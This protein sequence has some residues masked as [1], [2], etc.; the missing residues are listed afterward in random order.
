MSK[1]ISGWIRLLAVS[2]AIW[3]MNS[4][5]WAV[6]IE[7]IR[8]ENI[9][10]GEIDPASVTSYLMSK[11]GDDFDRG[12]VA[13]DVRTLQES[14]RF[15][16]VSVEVEQVG[17]G[18]DV[19]YSVERKLRL[20]TLKLE[21][22]EGISRSKARKVMA[23]REGDFLDEAALSVAA[24]RLEKEYEKRYYYNAKVTWKK[25]VDERNAAADIT[26]VVKEG[27]SV[28][29]K[30][31]EFDG[32]WAVEEK[33]LH[34]AMRQKTWSLLSLFNK[35]GRYK[36]GELEQD[37]ETIRNLYLNQGYLDVEVG[38][39]IVNVVD[40]ERVRITIPIDE[41]RIY[42]VREVVISGNEEYPEDIL[43]AQ[44]SIQPGTIA[45]T[46]EIE[47]SRVALQDYYGSRGYI[48]TRV[49]ADVQP[50]LDTGNVAVEFVVREGELASIRRI[51]IR[52]NDRTKDEVI[53]RELVVYPGEIYNEVKVKTSERRIQNLN[54]FQT[55]RSTPTATE[56]PGL[57]DMDLEVTEK[58]TGQFVVG[59]GFSS[60]DDL[61]GFME[62]SQ[63][64]FDLLGWPGFTGDGQKLRLR[65][66][67]GTQRQD[68]ELSFT[69]PWFLDRKLA[70]QTDF[71]RSDK[72]YLSSEYDQRN[73]GA[74]VGLAKALGRFFRLNVAYSL[75]EIVISDVAETASDII[76]EEEGARTKSALT[77]T[78][79][80]DSRDSFFVS[81]RGNRTS[82]TFEYAGGP[83]AGETDLYRLEAR[84]SH[85]VPLWLAHVLNLRGWA[86][87]V[88]PHGSSDRVPI[89]DRLFL[90]GARTLRGFEYRDVGP[91]DENGEPIGGSSGAF[92]SAE[93]TIPISKSFRVAAF[94]DIGMIWP[95]AYEFDTSTYN[96]DYGVGIR[97]DIPG[98]PLR[99]DYAW[100][101]EADEFNDR[102]SG[103]FNFM[104]GYVF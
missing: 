83:L 73:T 25:E 53:R 60:I 70:L 49:L 99:M 95:D 104:I 37:V 69:E 55:V 19:I 61:I 63:A 45:S 98:F 1:W 65:A 74:R 35:S 101:L 17:D 23:I 7:E 62:I 72:Q 89:F 13:R 90:G 8:I 30:E 58:R 42:L 38:E 14:G 41:G 31:I 92:A 21:G 24:R 57:Y 36:S 10:S 75:E 59:V 39:P 67:L 94:Y 32:N 22:L 18:V 6:R 9:G 56:D 76:K 84:T 33:V 4:S 77:T 85:Y 54:F 52:G 86:S 87:V 81:T 48:R 12:V 27:P 50:D 29:L 11:K 34:K 43:M 51:N 64:N 96:S 103:R 82:L 47:R 28:R 66:Q 79:T 88:E 20:R 15:A 16:Y 44:L 5:S 78:L 40:E 68:L 71:F 97:L 80:H 91:K 3:G 102:D 93:Y 2:V 46:L 26:F 100:P